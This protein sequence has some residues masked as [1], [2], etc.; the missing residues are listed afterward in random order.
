[1]ADENIITPDES[2]AIDPT[3]NDAPDVLDRLCEYDEESQSGCR[4]TQ[5]MF[6]LEEAYNTYVSP[7]MR[8]G[9]WDL[10]C[11]HE[12][13]LYY[14]RE[15]LQWNLTEDATERANNSDE[16]NDQ[17]VQIDAYAGRTSNEVSMDDV[18]DLV[19]SDTAGLP[20]FI[21]ETDRFFR[22]ENVGTDM[23]T[24]DNIT[25]ERLNIIRDSF[26]SDINPLLMDAEGNIY[27]KDGQAYCTN[28]LSFTENPNA[29]LGLMLQDVDNDK[30]NF[31][32]F[33][34]LT[35]EQE[36]FVT[37]LAQVDMQKEVEIINL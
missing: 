25:R 32:P 13:K 15:W 3:S 11:E 28:L 31:Y 36:A 35:A 7:E 37:T 10:F 26:T 24:T 30:I 8:W 21:D 9:Y 1:M 6:A 18:Y 27:I 4:R 17:L 29:K 33:E 23:V 5:T 12:D 20:V 34:E 2:N 16:L 22:F 19:H 14:D